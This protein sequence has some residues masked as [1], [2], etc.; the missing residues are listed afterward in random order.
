MDRKEEIEKYF[1][2]EL[3]GRDKWQL[4]E[5]VRGDDAL[6]GE[7]VK[8]QN[9]V[10]V[11]LLDYRKGDDEYAAA[12]FKKFKVKVRQKRINKLL[13]NVLKYAAVAAL[14]VLNAWLLFYK[15][16]D[17]QEYTVI[18][19]PKGQRASLNF[20]DGSSAWIS[21]NTTIRI[22]SDFNKKDR[23]VE[24]DGEGYFTVAKNEDKPFIVRTS[25]FEVKAIGT[26]FNVFAYSSSVRF[27][28]D[29][30]EGSV[31]VSVNKASGYK[32]GTGEPVKLVAG[33]KVVLAGNSLVKSES[34]LNNGEYLSKGIYTFANRPFGEVLEYLTLW[35]NVK[36]DIKDRSKLTHPITGK[37]R[38]NDEMKTI[39]TALQG[40]YPFRFNVVNEQ[41]MEI[42]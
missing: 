30:V 1:T 4:L 18:Q 41:F 31:E 6:R 29:L 17:K 19:A 11:T 34:K 28:T 25:R 22:S 23:T 36:F 3:A 16:A 42:Y 14:I 2:D 33:E 27:E 32:M 15:P 7:F 10:A 5:S 38:Q 35:Y 37:V 12:M 39:L 26:Q 20:A 21:P 24:L 9:S 13:L 8:I 40:V